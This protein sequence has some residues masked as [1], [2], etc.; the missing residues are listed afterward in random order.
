MITSEQLDECFRLLSESDGGQTLLQIAQILNQ[1]DEDE[2]S[3]NISPEFI[4]HYLVRNIATSPSSFDRKKAFMQF[5]NRPENKEYL[6]K[7]D[8]KGNSIAQIMVGLQKVYG[9]DLILAV[10]RNT[11]NVQSYRCS[12]PR[13]SE[14]NLHEDH[15]SFDS[16]LSLEVGGDSLLDY[17]ICQ[18]AYDQDV[19]ELA[20]EMLRMGISLNVCNHKVIAALLEGR[21]LHRE[22]AASSFGGVVVKKNPSLTEELCNFFIDEKREADLF[23]ELIRSLQQREK[24]HSAASSRSSSVSAFSPGR[25]SNSAGE[26]LMT[27]T[28]D[29]E[30]VL[31]EVLKHC[32]ENG[33]INVARE[34]LGRKESIPTF[35]LRRSGKRGED[36]R[37]VSSSSVELWRFLQAAERIRK[38][39]PDVFK[40]V[41]P[42]GNLLFEIIK[43]CERNISL[44]RAA[45]NIIM[46]D[47]DPAEIL[48]LVDK[49][50]RTALFLACQEGWDEAIEAM[51]D[52]VLI[53]DMDFVGDTPLGIIAAKGFVKSCAILLRK[54]VDIESSQS[55]TRPL[56]NAVA[57]NKEGVAYLLLENGAN[58]NALSLVIHDGFFTKYKTALEAA[59]EGE[60]STM[61]KLLVLKSANVKDKN[62]QYFPYYLQY[63]NSDLQLKLA[64]DKIEL[65]A[66]EHKFSNF[67]VQSAQ[68]K[69]PEECL[70][71]KQILQKMMLFGNLEYAE[72]ILKIVDNGV[73]NVAIDAMIKMKE[74][75]NYC[76]EAPEYPEADLRI[77]VVQSMM[78]RIFECDGQDD[79]SIAN[80]LLEDISMA[81]VVFEI[82]DSA[83]LSDAK[84]V[85]PKGDVARMA[86][87]ARAGNFQHVLDIYNSH[88]DLVRRAQDSRGPS[89]AP[90]PASLGSFPTR[91]AAVAAASEV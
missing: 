48:K 44:F 25:R 81:K 29:A 57:K 84:I 60:N 6:T 23:F 36:G 4:I 3:Q 38:L 5:C 63:K 66:M 49:K 1:P 31:K 58:S 12:S 65:E 30:C 67:I 56:Y 27:A 9:K 14:V 33:S 73:I 47:P 68:S 72:K 34:T 64:L 88:S 85:I 79:F 13:I 28:K 54:G 77:K 78:A 35:L 18:K 41:G 89:A 24:G 39:T 86:N 82:I 69:S 76:K 87:E 43:Y 11:Q 40:D 20:V 8:E 50:Q 15:T 21:A 61:V 51:Y 7:R 53:E 52:P 70:E 91:N 55:R 80:N 71:L 22:G 42:E 26:G 45:L 46:T 37:A 75:C 2:F 83:S 74:F 16:L 19:A 90:R 10:L 62:G 59:C 17:M 32:L